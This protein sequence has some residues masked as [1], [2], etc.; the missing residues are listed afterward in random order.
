MSTSL[1]PASPPAGVQPAAAP[2][3]LAPPMRTAGGPF[4]PS[5]R[6]KDLTGRRFGRWTVIEY[7]GADYP[8]LQSRWLVACDCGVRRVVQAR[9]LLGGN[10]RSCG[11]FHSHEVSSRRRAK[12]LGRRFGRLLVTGFVGVTAKHTTRWKVVCDCGAEKEAGAHELLRGN[13]TSCG[14]YNREITSARVG[15]LGT[16]WNPNLT[17]EHRAARRLGTESFSRMSIVN[18]SARL[19][20]KKTCVVCGDGCCSLHVHHLEPW[21]SEEALRYL[22]ANLVT[23]CQ[24]CHEL[25]HR[26]YGHD[27]GLDDFREYFTEFSDNQERISA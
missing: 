9:T 4:F 24:S 1:Q 3:D 11:C 25:F 7:R 8:D 21:H 22:P 27:A 13:V 18:R 20:D 16:N 2:A 6:T 26:I 10:S 23:L 12:L 5:P 17:D 14:C 19:R 15:S